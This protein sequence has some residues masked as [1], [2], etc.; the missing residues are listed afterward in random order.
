MCDVDCI[1]TVSIIICKFFSGETQLITKRRSNCEA[2]GVL[3]GGNASSGCNGFEFETQRYET[4]IYIYRVLF[5][6]E[7]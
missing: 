4:Y 1:D 2:F 5:L 3:L 6:I 7:I